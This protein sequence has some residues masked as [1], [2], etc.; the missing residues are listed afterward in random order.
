MGRGA[1]PGSACGESDVVIRG[2]VRVTIRCLKVRQWPVPHPR[3][4]EGVVSL[5]SRLLD[6]V[7]CP[8]T[9]SPLAQM[10]QSQLEILNVQIAAAKI[11]TRGD[12]LIT[13]PLTEALIT[14]DGKLAYPVLDGIPVL[15]EEQG[16]VLAQL[17]A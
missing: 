5:D 2:A 6:I 14:R 13:E 11:K 12:T 8:V 15:L 17:E 1:A 9:Y 10:P 7:C 16:I 3:K 4:E